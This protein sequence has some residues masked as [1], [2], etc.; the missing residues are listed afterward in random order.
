MSIKDL[1]EA[2]DKKILFESKETFKQDE[3]TPVVIN[4]PPQKGQKGKPLPPQKGGKQIDVEVINTGKPE[5]QDGDSEDPQDADGGDPQ[6]GDESQKET[7]KTSKPGEGKEKGKPKTVDSHEIMNKWTDTGEAKEIAEKIL[8]K[9][10]KIRQE[11]GEGEAGAGA[12]E[13]HFMDKLRKSHEP[14]INWVQELKKKLTAFK[15]KTSAEANQWSRKSADRYKEGQGVQKSKAYHQW[16][17][18]PRSHSGGQMI[19]KGPYVK[20]PISEMVLIVALDTSGSIPATTVS[21]VFAEMDKIAKG[22][23]AGI[24]HGGVSLEGKVYF[25]TWDSNVQQVEEYKPGEWKKYAKGERT[26]KGGGG[27]APNHI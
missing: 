9:S 6:D 16:L 11:R 26:V 25:M 12:G 4:P 18:D 23:K 10:Q 3:L 17:K 8:E 24:S 15:S 19:F 27:T 7:K 14:K 5:P 22:F 1:L 13:G 20:A 21:K 2:L